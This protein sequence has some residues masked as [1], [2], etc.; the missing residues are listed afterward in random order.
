ML[1]GICV[2][3]MIA[4]NNFAGALVNRFFLGVFEAAVTPGL[5]LMTGAFCAQSEALN[6]DL[7]LTGFWYTRAESPLRQ[8]IW[9]S[10]VGWGGM[11]GS[12]MAAGLERSPESNVVPRWQMIF[13]NL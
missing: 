9:Y 3:V 5:S 13:S 2:L 1:W 7:S 10:S 12:L 6:A 8:T 4:C 11:I